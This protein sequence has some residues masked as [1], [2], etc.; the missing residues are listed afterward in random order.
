MVR[1]D[2]LSSVPPY[3]QPPM[4]HVPCAMRETFISVPKITLYSMCLILL[5]EMR[6]AYFQL[7][8]VLQVR[9]LRSVAHRKTCSLPFPIRSCAPKPAMRRGAYDL[10]FRLAP[11]DPDKRV[12]SQ[13]KRKFPAAE[14]FL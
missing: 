12:I 7:T 11:G 5:Y 1:I 4:A 14:Q 3:I 6:S 10:E 2:S 9:L 8:L 13:R